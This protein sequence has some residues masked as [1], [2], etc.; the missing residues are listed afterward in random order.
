VGYCD[1]DHTHIATTTLGYLTPEVG[2][3]IVR[4]IVSNWRASGI[5]SA[6]SGNRLNITTGKD[7]ALTGIG[8]TG[9]NQQRPNQVST[10]YY[11]KTLTNWFNAAAFAQPDTGT[12][13]NLA[14]NAVVGPA[15]WNVDLAVSRLIALGPTQHVELR[16]ESFN[17]LNHFN[18]GDPLVNFNAGTFGRITTQAGAPRIMQFGIKYD[19]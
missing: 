2:K 12:L 16:L 6:R 19:F 1:Q 3:G 8:T 11:R 18:W 17:L 4:T 14:R 15:Y 9:N 5:F 13:G 10:D 7:I